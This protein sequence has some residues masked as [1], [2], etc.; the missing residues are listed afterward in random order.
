MVKCYLSQFPCFPVSLNSKKTKVPKSI[1]SPPPP[2]CLLS[3]F[4]IS[5]YPLDSQVLVDVRR[6][7]GD[8]SYCPRD[9]RELC[10]H[11]FTT[12]YMASE[13]SSEDTRSRAKGL[14]SQIG[15]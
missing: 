3:V 9:P 1:L 10:G 4:V 8:D 7:V 12:C 15:R 5:P 14:A 2:S 13:N 11:I 6:V